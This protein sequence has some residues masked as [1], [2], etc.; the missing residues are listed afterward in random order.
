MAR[1]QHGY[2]SLITVQPPGSNIYLSPKLSIFLLLTQVFIFFTPSCIVGNC[3]VNEKWTHYIHIRREEQSK[4]SKSHKKPIHQNFSNFGSY[5][6]LD[7]PPELGIND[8]YFFKQ[9]KYF[10]RP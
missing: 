10:T 9:Y 5:A 7:V 2:I 4:C 8:L 6:T 1:T 3:T